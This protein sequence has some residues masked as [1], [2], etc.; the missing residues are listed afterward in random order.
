MGQPEHIPWLR[1]VSVSEDDVLSLA[2]GMKFALS[3]PRFTHFGSSVVEI[4]GRDL[5]CEEHKFVWKPFE[6]VI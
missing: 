4:E 6:L 5:V 3:R 1:L 2:G